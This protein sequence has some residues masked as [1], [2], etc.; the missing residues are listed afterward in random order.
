[1]YYYC[2]MLKEFFTYTSLIHSY[3]RLLMT[4]QR[5]VGLDGLGARMTKYVHLML[6]YVVLCVSMTNIED[7]N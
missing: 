4:L 1:M 3:W 5:D 2:H 7:Q 6:Y